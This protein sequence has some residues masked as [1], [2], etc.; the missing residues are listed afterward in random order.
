MRWSG[1]RRAVAATV[2][3]FGLTSTPMATLFAQPDETREQPNIVIIL[4]EDLGYDDVGIYG[5]KTIATPN[6]DA[7]AAPAC[8]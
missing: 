4:A 8:G 2:V 1:T 7:L 5:S 6:I 3:A